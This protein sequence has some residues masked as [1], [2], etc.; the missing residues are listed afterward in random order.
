MPAPS[1]DERRHHAAPLRET[2]SQLRLRE[3]LNEVQIRI[4][5]VVDARD[6]MDRLVEAM[7]VVTSGLELD[8]TLRTIVHTAIE[9]VD[10]RYGALGVRGQGHELSEFLYEGIDAATRESIGPLPAGGGVLGQVIDHPEPLRLDDLTQHPASIGFPV[11]H[12]PMTSF[13]GVPVRI[14]DEVFGNLYLT[15]KSNGQSF[16]VEDEVM[17]QAL[18]SAAGVAIENARLYE[19]VRTRQQL[20]EATRDIGTE[21][22]AGADGPTVFRLITR[23]AAE[24]ARADTSFLAVPE[25][26]T[27]P[28]AAIVVTEATGHDS[29]RMIHMPLS[30][31]GTPIGR[32]YRDRAPSRFEEFDNRNPVLVD[33]TGPALVL[34]LRAADSASGILVILRRKGAQQFSDD[35]FETMITFADHAALALQMSTAQRQ[36]REL[37]VLTDRDRIARDLHDHAIQLIFAVGLSLQG[38]V[39]RAQ[40]PEVRRRVLIAIDE[41]QDVVQDIRSTIFGLQ[42]GLAGPARLRE[43]LD[44]AIAQLKRNSAIKATLHVS[45]PLSIVNSTLA[46]DAEAVVREAV[47]NAVRHSWATTIA[48]TVTVDESLTIEVTDNGGGLPATLTRSGLDDLDERARAAKGSFTVLSVP[49]GGVHL[50]WTV[51]LG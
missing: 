27:L 38:T 39:T 7:L 48:V 40:S 3:L 43:R 36:M 42:S 10:A 50:V 33:H 46:D 41:L 5:K 31:S 34:P 19:R 23:L 25:D 51:P 49:G 47:S 9:L 21:L 4:A 14:R 12:P 30:V 20:I 28:A 11:N 8:E 32:A 17:L 18:A 1:G 24:L 22:L 44:L 37:D 13:L 16:T 15:E 6:R 26:P 29:D 2:L 35:E 45:G